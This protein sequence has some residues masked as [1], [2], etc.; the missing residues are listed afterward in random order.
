M[1]KPQPRVNEVNKPY[2]DGVNAGVLSL[3]RCKNAACGQTIFY[4]RVCCPFCRCVELEW[5]SSKGRGSVVS[6]T[7][8]HRPHHDG[9]NPEVPYVFAAVKLSEG[10]LMYGQMPGAPTDGNALIGCAVK[11]DFVPHGAN[12]KMVV[13]RLIDS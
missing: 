10:V 7:V 9:F 4:P 13:F 11:A 3:Q 12:R 5:I 1:D 6:T 2:W 8:V